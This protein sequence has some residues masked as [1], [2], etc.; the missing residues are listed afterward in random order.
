MS[1]ALEK[2]RAKVKKRQA[3]EKL[4]RELRDKLADRLEDLFTDP[5]TGDFF[6]E[7]TNWV[8][9]V[10]KSLYRLPPRAWGYHDI[11][12]CFQAACDDLRIDY[13]ER[14]AF[15]DEIFH[16]VRR[17]DRGDGA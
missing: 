3:F 5:V 14:D 17:A 7:E 4:L 9:Q 13:G 8:Y 1:D 15:A 6:A 11:Q 16:V 10:R 12:G 2:I